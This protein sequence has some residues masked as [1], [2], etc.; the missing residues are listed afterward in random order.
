MKILIITNY[1][2]PEIRSASHLLYELS[3]SLVNDS[4]EVTVVTGFPRS[5]EESPEHYKRKFFVR[6]IMNGIK[7][8][9]LATI[10]LHKSIPIVRGLDHF[11]L[12][13]VFFLGGLISGKQDVILVYSPPLPLGLSAYIL[14]RIK[15]IPFIFNVQDI[16]PQCIIDLGILRNPILIKLLEAIEKFIY[17]RATNITVHSEGNREYLLSKI[18]DSKLLVIPNWVDTHSIKPAERFNKF[19]RE[20]N[21]GA[22]FIVSFAG[23][24]N[25]SQDL[26]NVI[27]SAKLLQSYEDILFLLIG[28]GAQKEDLKKK[29]ESLKLN[30]VRFLP[31]Q[32]REKYP[33]VL[34]ASDI[35]LV[36]L[37]KEVVTPVVPAKLLSIMASGRPVIGSLNANG[38]AAK[39]IESAQCGYR[40]EPGNPAMLAQAVLELYN[41]PTLLEKFG[42]NGRAYAEKHF[43]RPVCTRRYEEALRKAVEMK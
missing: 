13:L 37:R 19:R 9:R 14:S 21:L 31:L 12:S 29:A 30:N 42:R 2:P 34:N 24:I 17:K 1:F 26:D 7:V 32:P 16:Y 38:D 22:K 5:I 39:I 11:L 27:E 4:H 43:S 15:S 20:H 23:I 3:E 36:T 28:D 18:A 8:I 10:P 40:V 25:F 35:C 33:Y 41:N 6:E